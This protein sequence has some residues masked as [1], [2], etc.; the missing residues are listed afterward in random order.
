MVT[1]FLDTN[2]AEGWAGQKRPRGEGRCPGKYEGTPS[3]S[4]FGGAG[5]GLEGEKEEG[6]RVNV[7]KR[8]PLSPF[9]PSHP[10]PT[11]LPAL[12]ML[13]SPVFMG[14]SGL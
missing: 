11:L 4:G 10:S 1:L 8:S 5:G 2:G 14:G 12:Q 13:E 9:H 7:G 6:R 3:K